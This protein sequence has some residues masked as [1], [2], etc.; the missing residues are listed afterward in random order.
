[1]DFKKYPIHQS[2]ISKF[3]YKGNEREFC[4]KQIYHTEWIQDVPRFISIE[5]E[6]GNFFETLCI[7]SGVGGRKTIDL[8]RKA[9]TKLQTAQNEVAKKEGKKQ[10]N[11]PQKKIGQ[12]RLEEQ[13]YVF[14]QLCV[15]YGITVIPT[16]ILENGKI[17]YGNTQIPL[18]VQWEED[19]TVY[20]QMTYDIFP[21]IMLGAEEKFYLAII[22]LKTTGDIHNTYGKYCYGDPSNLD[23]I[24]G[25]MY[26][27]G[28]R[29]ISFD[30]NP[31]L[32]DIISTKAL[33][34]INRNDIKFIMWVFDYKKQEPENKFI[35][36][37]WNSLVKAELFESIRKTISTIEI[38]EQLGWPTTPEYKF[39]LNCPLK[40]CPDRTMIEKI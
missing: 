35:E 19:P 36:V 11:K 22:D 9:L 39:C 33:T 8:P 27:Y 26:H 20:L 13:E 25:H 14:R 30:L 31:H 10:P 24:Q 21:T 12:I 28:A 38:N 4:P 37:E 7:G 1:M 32:V 15:K 16:E 5:M 23:K 29:H 6:H 40:K 17:I 3:L 18:L 2:L 34:L